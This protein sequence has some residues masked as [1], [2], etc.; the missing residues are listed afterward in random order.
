MANARTGLET[1]LLF[2]V[3]HRTTLILSERGAGKK[4]S[5]GVLDASA[6]GR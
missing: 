3:A 5:D 2:S 1:H 6:R 4:K